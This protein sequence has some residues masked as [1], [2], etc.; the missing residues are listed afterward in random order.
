MS[1]GRRKARALICSVGR[2]GIGQ[3][4]GIGV[5]RG[6]FGKPTYLFRTDPATQT[7]LFAQYC[8]NCGPI[9]LE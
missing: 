5:A 6:R 7:E 9:V 3:G 4:H 1:R 2:G 8:F